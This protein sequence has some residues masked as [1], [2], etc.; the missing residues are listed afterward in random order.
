MVGEACHK[1]QVV[2]C[3]SAKII[4]NNGISAQIMNNE[5]HKKL[6]LTKLTIIRYHTKT[7]NT[8]KHNHTL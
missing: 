4:L 7:Y 6:I 8:I 2:S 5:I 3:A 1:I